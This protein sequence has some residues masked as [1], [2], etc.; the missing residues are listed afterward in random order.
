MSG[1]TEVAHQPATPDPRPA[2]TAP[3]PYHF[4]SFERRALANGVRVVVAPVHKLPL[5]TVIALVDAG[6]VLDP[7]GREGLAQL[8]ARALTEGT[9][10][11]PVE[12]LTERV[13]RLGTSLDASADWDTALAQLTVAAQRL[14]EAMRLLGE[15]LREPAFPEREVE[16]LKSERLAERL[17]LKTEPR[18]LADEMFERFTYA[19]AARY[20]RP[21]GG[22]EATVAALGRDDVVRFYRDHYRPSR[23]TLVIAGDVTADEAERVVAAA[24][25]DWRDDAGATGVAAGLGDGRAPN[26]AAVAAGAATTTAVR[27]APPH[28][29]VA[30]NSGDAAHRNSAPGT[31]T[32]SDGRPVDAPAR[33][34]RAVHVVANADAPQSE[35]RVGHVGVPRRHPDYFAIV[36]MNALLGGLFS[37]RINLNLREA[38]AYTYGAHSSYDWR[39]A[40]GPFVVS[41]AVKSDVTDAAAREVLFEIDRL[42]AEPV[43]AEE[44]SLAT[45]YLDG[46]FPIRYETTAAIAVALANLVLYDQPADYFDRY[47]ER[48]RALTADDVLRA[49]RDHLHPD[50]LQIVV[51]GDPAAVRAPL[52]ALAAGPVIAYD[53]EGKPVD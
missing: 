28:G 32:S 44:L 33:L 10:S 4:P 40:S 31:A 25:G 15:V 43:S 49:A 17:A 47:R 46:V 9:A 51:V 42:R 5:V 52:E 38:H 39:R 14:P 29:E 41:T 2:P 36:V 20:S 50:R 27:G 24:F 12:A 23:T 48:I 26:A 19:P 18:G 8:T 6:A 45:S 35:L 7:E 3:R 11:S 34:T 1:T 37:S 13:E 53:A 21:E 30:K 16:R 22:S